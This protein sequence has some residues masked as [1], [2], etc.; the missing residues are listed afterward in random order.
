MFKKFAVFMELKFAVFASIYQYSPFKSN[1][2]ISHPYSHF[3][4]F[5]SLQR[6]NDSSS[7]CT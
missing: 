2:C 3:F 5:C 7:R 4:T 1:E 6:S